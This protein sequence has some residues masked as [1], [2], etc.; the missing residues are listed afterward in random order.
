MPYQFIRHKYGLNTAKIR[1]RYG[2]NTA[3][4]GVILKYSGGVPGIFEE[5]L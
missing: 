1:L 4:R 3:K 2:L 5:R